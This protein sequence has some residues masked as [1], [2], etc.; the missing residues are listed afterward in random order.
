MGVGGWFRDLAHHHRAS[1][2]GPFF[3]AG[4]WWRSEQPAPRPAMKAPVQ[5][6]L[7]S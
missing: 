4:K 1:E 3:A 2:C 5:A 7:F 6:E